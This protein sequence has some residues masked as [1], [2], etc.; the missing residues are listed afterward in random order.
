MKATHRGKLNKSESYRLIEAYF[1]SGELSSVFYSRVGL[2]EGLFYKWRRRYLQ[3]H[4][5]ASNQLGIPVRG[6]SRIDG[7][8]NKSTSKMQSTLSGF[9]RVDISEPHIPITSTSSLSTY[10]LSYP[11]WCCFASSCRYCLL[12]CYGINQTLLI[13]LCLV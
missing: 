8:N 9:A 7:K 12:L 6:D 11:Q 5:Q 13:E 10:E 1:S 3:D 2:S 4:P